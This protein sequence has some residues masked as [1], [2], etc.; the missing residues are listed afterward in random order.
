MGILAT[1]ADAPF[2]VFFGSIVLQELCR[3]HSMV[4]QYSS[5]ESAG[6][7][8]DPNDVPNPLM[9]VHHRS[10][11]ANECVE[12]VGKG[13]DTLQRLCNVRL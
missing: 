9:L 13:S 11:L 1:T 7:M 12:F 4:F 2:Y 5:S 6:D 8:R 3:P 10:Q